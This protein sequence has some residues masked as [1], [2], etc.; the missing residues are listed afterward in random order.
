MQKMPGGGERC[1]QVDTSYMRDPDGKPIGQVEIVTDI[2]SKWEVENMHLKLGQRQ[3]LGG[4]R[5]QPP[6]GT[7]GAVRE[8]E[9]LAAA[10]RRM[11]AGAAKVDVLLSE[12]ARASAEQSQGISAV[13]QGLHQ[14]EQASLRSS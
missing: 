3:P 10:L 4:E 13:S 7:A 5:G 12:I 9:N 8:G 1:M 14:L 6:D 2:H 11:D